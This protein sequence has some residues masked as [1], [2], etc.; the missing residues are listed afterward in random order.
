MGLQTLRVMQRRAAQITGG[1]FKTTAGAALGRE[2]SPG[3]GGH[4]LGASSTQL[5]SK[6]SGEPS[7]RGHPRYQKG[8]VT[9]G[10]MHYRQQRSI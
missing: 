6:H 10:S 4:C 7:L 5:T 3:A 2:A 9:G 1:A 8:D